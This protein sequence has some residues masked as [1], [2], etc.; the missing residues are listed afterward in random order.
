MFLPEVLEIT[1]ESDSSLEELNNE[2][3]ELFIVLMNKS[4][5][6]A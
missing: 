6:I 2:A 5:E 3:I 1:N 4:T